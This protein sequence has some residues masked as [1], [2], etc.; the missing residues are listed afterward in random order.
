MNVSGHIGGNEAYD[1]ADG[2]LAGCLRNG[3]LL[4][5]PTAVDIEDKDDTKTTA[6]GLAKVRKLASEQVKGINFSKVIT[7]F[8]GLRSVG[9]S[10]DFIINMP[11]P[12]F[13]NAAD[14]GKSL[15][16]QVVFY[17]IHLTPPAAAP[18]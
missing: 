17:G 16:P 11:T 6:E 8:T 15:L 18:A 12:G 2:S 13:V 5:G 14:S 9:S 1:T 3:N 10:G 4:V 7:S